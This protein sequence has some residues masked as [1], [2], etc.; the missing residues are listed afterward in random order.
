MKE[1]KME[2]ILPFRF[3]VDDA[4]SL[5]QTLTANLGEEPVTLQ[6]AQLAGNSNS[7]AALPT[8]ILRS[9]FVTFFVSK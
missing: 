8:G 6:N 7:K 5:T 4:E 1:E 9:A 3:W 2:R